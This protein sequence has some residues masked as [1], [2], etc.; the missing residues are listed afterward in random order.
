MLAVMESASDRRSGAKA[1]IVV[2]SDVAF[3]MGR[4]VALR[5]QETTEPGSVQIEECAE[6]RHGF[7]CLSGPDA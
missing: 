5:S 7:R 3:G 2:G 1:A 6:P 4:M